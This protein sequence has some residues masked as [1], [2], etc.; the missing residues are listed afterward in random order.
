MLGSFGVQWKAFLSSSRFSHRS[1]LGPFFIVVVCSLARSL[2][3]APLA[4]N[5]FNNY[6]QRCFLA[7]RCLGT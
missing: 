1:V 7:R 6:I 3:A 5:S 4:L 2:A